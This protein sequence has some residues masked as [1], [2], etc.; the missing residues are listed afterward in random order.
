MAVLVAIPT[1]NLGRYSCYLAIW[2]ATYL[3]TQGI[4]VAQ[5]P[6]NFILPNLILPRYLASYLAKQARYRY[7]T[8]Y[9][10]P[11]Q[12]VKYLAQQLPSYLPTYLVRQANKLPSQVGRQVGPPNQPTYS[13]VVTY[14]CKIVFYNNFLYTQAYLG[15]RND[16]QLGTYTQPR[17]AQ[18]YTKL[19]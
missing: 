4:Q 2:Q 19:L 18:V 5:Q 10:L 9:L 6:I 12:V 11:T 16:R 15:D 14:L 1:T 8:T 13:Q 7:L 3:A 17:Q